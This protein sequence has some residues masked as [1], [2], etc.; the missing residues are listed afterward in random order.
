DDRLVDRLGPMAPPGLAWIGA[1]APEAWTEALA[2]RGDH[3][4]ANARI[5]AACLAAIGVDGADDPAR[6]LTAAP[7]YEPLP[8]RLTTIAAHHGVEFVDDS[9]STNVLPTVA[10]LD[11]FAGRPVALLAG[12]QDRGIDYGPLAEHLSAR[13]QPTVLVTLPPGGERIGVLARAL[14][15]G[16]EDAADMTTAVAFAERWCRA[17]GGGV[18]L[19]SPAAPSYGPYRDYRERAEHFA[20]AV[21]ATT[22]S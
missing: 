15:V 16:T 18:V 8:S 11:V 2:L 20:A 17:A 7:G 3:N 4:R 10:A 6:L 13:G 5:A 19:L 9:L 1:G 14:D 12:G 22:G 21:A